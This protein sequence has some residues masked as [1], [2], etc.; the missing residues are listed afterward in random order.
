[1]VF[2]FL[3]FTKEKGKENENEAWKGALWL[4]SGTGMS[5]NDEHLDFARWK[6]DWPSEAEA[7]L[8]IRFSVP[9]RSRGPPDMIPSIE[10]GG[11]VFPYNP[12]LNTSPSSS[13]S[14]TR[15]YPP[16]W[17]CRLQRRERHKQC[18]PYSPRP[19]R[20]SLQW[21]EPAHALP[22]IVFRP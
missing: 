3:K 2:L 7:M 11:F 15:P 21:R 9:E 17:R 16:S 4:R 5:A 6:P 1:M 13:S 14:Q 20:F 8:A 18:H 10:I 22:A 19:F 12:P